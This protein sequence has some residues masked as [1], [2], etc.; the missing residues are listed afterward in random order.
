MTVEVTELGLISGWKILKH[1]ILEEGEENGKKKVHFATICV[2]ITL[3]AM[4]AMVF[5]CTYII[6]REECSSFENRGLPWEEEEEQK[7]SL[8]CLGFIFFTKPQR[9]AVNTERP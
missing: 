1:K 2:K 3:E 7:W 6:N 5:E 4:H 8:E 9:S